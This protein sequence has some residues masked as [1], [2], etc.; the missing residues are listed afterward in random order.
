MV[1]KKGKYGLYIVC[2]DNKYSLKGVVRKPED[3]IQLEDVLDILLGKKSSNPKVLQIVTESLSI[4]KGKYGPY[5]FYKTATMK[6]PRF[7]NLKN[8]EW[9]SMQKQEILGWCKEEYGI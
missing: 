1:L 9:K 2:G 7:L 6:K 3:N 4:R 5:I 8:I